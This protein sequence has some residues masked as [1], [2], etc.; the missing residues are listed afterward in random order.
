M[1]DT[2]DW[3]R[4]VILDMDNQ[5]EPITRGDLAD[6]ATAR[7]AAS[8]EE[9]LTALR[10]RDNWPAGHVRV[11]YDPPRQIAPPPIPDPA[12]EATRSLWEDVFAD[13]TVAAA[14]ERIRAGEIRGESDRVRAANANFEAL[15]GAQVPPICQYQS[16]TAGPPGNI[17]W[18]R[19]VES[20]DVRED[21]MSM[22]GGTYLNPPVGQ[23]DYWVQ[24]GT[25]CIVAI[26]RRHGRVQPSAVGRRYPQHD[27]QLYIYLP[28]DIWYLLPD[29]E[30]RQEY[31]W[32]GRA[33]A[34]L[35]SWVTQPRG[36]RVARG[37]QRAY[38]ELE[39]AMEAARNSTDVTEFSTMEDALTHIREL[40]RA[41]ENHTPFTPPL[42]PH[43]V[44]N[45]LTNFRGWVTVMAQSHDTTLD[46]VRD[47]VRVEV[48][49]QPATTV[50]SKPDST[51]RRSAVENR[52]RRNIRIRSN[53]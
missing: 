3:E 47:L 9:L 33:A 51:P 21:G 41:V 26:Q 7:P 36:M 39:T 48:G 53:E 29:G 28:D 37:L 10:N 1:A 25:L 24:P 34:L 49:A 22:F 32:H 45:I 14:M 20:I 17:V 40:L 15:Y 23:T 19:Q 52:Q 11:D 38:A 30:F 35:Q 31:G 43:S 16:Q 12:A 50:G 8:M 13:P 5:G 4:E 42:Q 46:S 44:A 2:E 6:M 27:L 18:I